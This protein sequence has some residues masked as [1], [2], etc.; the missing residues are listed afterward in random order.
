VDAEMS[1][2][3]QQAGRTAAQGRLLEAVY[4]K[5]HYDFRHYA[6]PSL[7]RCIARAQAAL[8][9]A[10]IDQLIR[11]ILAKEATFVRFL[12]HMTIQTSD[13]FR[14]PGYFLALRQ[15]VLPHLA[16]YPVIRIWVAGCGAGEEAY[17]LAILLHEAGLLE[18]SQIYATDIDPESLRRARSGTYDSRRLPG[19]TTNHVAAGGKAALSEYYSSASSAIAF[20]RFLAKRIVFSDHSLATDGVFAEVQLV[21]CRNVLIYFERSLQERS[22][23]LF[24]QSLCPRGFL[25]LGSKETLAFS[26]HAA[27]FGPFV[28][29]QRIYRVKP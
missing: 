6:G 24:L 23:D 28:A 7:E 20:A 19:F 21:S 17:S 12:R 3:L 11:A 13:L 25:G 10:T 8:G 26:S 9:C 1:E 4:Q 14:D 16:T 2:P 5:Y 18:R 15:A 29:D 22:V 27:S